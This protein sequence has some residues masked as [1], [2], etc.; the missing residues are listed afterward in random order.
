MNNMHAM[1]AAANEM[2]QP[3]GIS[4]SNAQA[5]VRA[6]KSFVKSMKQILNQ[7]RSYEASTHIAPDY[8]LQDETKPCMQYLDYS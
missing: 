6:S 2:G 1:K 4:P 8:D 3:C 7:A 5:M